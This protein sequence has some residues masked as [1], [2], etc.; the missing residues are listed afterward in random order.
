L[1]RRA[2]AWRESADVEAKRGPFARPTRRRL[3]VVTKRARVASG[4]A[5]SG[6]ASRPGG[7]SRSA[8]H[9]AP[10]KSFPQRTSAGNAR[11]AG[12]MPGVSARQKEMEMRLMNLIDIMQDDHDCP[13]PPESAAS[14]WT[15][16]EVPHTPTSLLWRRPTASTRPTRRRARIHH[17]GVVA[18]RLS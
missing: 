6:V 2:L 13:E 9:V 15:E 12:T 18:L 17:G 1:Q 16:T 14:E 4:C 11:V 10:H 7:C 5:S 3:P 8:S